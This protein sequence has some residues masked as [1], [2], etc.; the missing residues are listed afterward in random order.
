[1]DRSALLLA[2]ANVVWLLASGCSDGPTGPRE[3]SAERDTVV[4]AFTGDKAVPGEKMELRMLGGQTGRLFEQRTLR[5]PNDLRFSG[6]TM[7]ADSLRREAVGVLAPNNEFERT[8]FT[9]FQVFGLTTSRSKRWSDIEAD[10]EGKIRLI[11]LLGG[12]SDRLFLLSEGA[13]DDEYGIAILSQPDWQIA[14][15]LG[16]FI[17]PALSGP[18]EVAPDRGSGRGLIVVGGVRTPEADRLMI[19]DR[20]SLE[21]RDSVFVGPTLDD[22]SSRLTR[23][24]GLASQG[25]GR[26]VVAL[27]LDSLLKVD[28]RK[29]R[30][31]ARRRRVR[32]GVS[33]KMAVTSNPPRIF[34]TDRGVFDHP[35]SGRLQVYGG[36]DLADLGTVDLRTDKFREM[37][38]S[39]FRAPAMNDVAVGDGGDRLFVISGTGLIGGFGQR[40]SLTVVD[41]TEMRRVRTQVFDRFSLFGVVA[42]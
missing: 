13:N 5:L 26:H 24:R 1:M 42:F 35:G 19:Y 23:L 40:A 7:V 2:L 36:E 14:G 21:L 34:L 33:G 15:F 8:R 32:P 12:N 3:T 6:L 25:D 11:R 28:V 41:V 4:L 27:T 20:R 22:L 29:P 16:R 39:A 37:F 17:D 10:F 9:A 30:V 38:G 18:A 31:V